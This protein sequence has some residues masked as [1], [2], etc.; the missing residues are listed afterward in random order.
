[1]WKGYSDVFVARRGCAAA[2]AFVTAL[3]AMRAAGIYLELAVHSA[4]NCAETNA[5]LGKWPILSLWT[6]RRNDA[7]AYRD[8]SLSDAPPTVMHPIKLNSPVN[9][10]VA[11]ELRDNAWAS[12]DN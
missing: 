5:L 6:D 7:L 8:A 11:V 9:I 10:A 1:M 2:D 3:E 4:A 12:L